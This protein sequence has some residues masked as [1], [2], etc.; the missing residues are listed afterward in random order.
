MT[1]FKVVCITEDVVDEDSLFSAGGIVF[2]YFMGG[3]FGED[4]RVAFS[5]IDNAVGE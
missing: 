4:N 3:Q 5:F 2:P 1:Q